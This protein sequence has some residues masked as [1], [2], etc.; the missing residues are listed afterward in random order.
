MSAKKRRIVNKN[1]K[2]S[3]GK[4]IARNGKKSTM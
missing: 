3:L 2:Y 1:K 4:L